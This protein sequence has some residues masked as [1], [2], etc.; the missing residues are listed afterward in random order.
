MYKAKP[1]QLRPFPDFN[2]PLIRFYVEVI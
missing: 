2:G 1:I